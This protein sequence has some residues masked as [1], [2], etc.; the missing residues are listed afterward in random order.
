[1]ID[2]NEYDFMFGAG[3]DLTDEDAFRALPQNA[4]SVKVG[5]GRTA[6]RYRTKSWQTLRKVL[7]RFA[8]IDKTE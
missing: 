4:I 5:L 8:E 3:D 1:L 6:A 7:K 2:H